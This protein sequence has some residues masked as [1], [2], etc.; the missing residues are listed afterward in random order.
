MALS[1]K[2]IKGKLNYL[3]VSK[4]LIKKYFVIIN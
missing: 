2:N 3:I 4:N 1:I